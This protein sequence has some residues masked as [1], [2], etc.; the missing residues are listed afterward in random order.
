MTADPYAN[1]PCGSG[2][3]LKFCCGPHWPEIERIER[4]FDSQ[5]DLAAL[6]AINKL[7]ATLPHHAH[8]MNMKIDLLFAQG[9]RE[10]AEAL[11]KEFIAAHPDNVN[12][13][14]RRAAELLDAGEIEQAARLW[15]DTFASTGNT[16][17]GVGL[18]VARATA[19]AALMAGHFAAGRTLLNILMA[20]DPKDTT[21]RDLAVQMMSADGQPPICR[22]LPPLRQRPVDPRWND[23]FAAALAPTPLADFPRAEALFAVLSEKAANEP[24][25]WGNLALLRA[26]LA[27][28]Q[29]AS[30]AYARLAACD[31][32][33]DDA[34]EAEALSVVYRQ[35]ASGAIVEILKAAFELSDVDRALE[36]LSAEKRCGRLPSEM[37]RRDDEDG[38]PP[39]A[40]FLLLDRPQI[41]DA[42]QVEAHDIPV[43][44]G[45]ISIFGK[46]T[47]RPAR[48]VLGAFGQPAFDQA[49][50][51]VRQL[52]GEPLPPF[53]EREIVG[54][55]LAEQHAMSWRP[56]LPA[57]TTA[58]RYYELQVA[59]ER[60]AVQK[61]WPDTPNLALDGKSPRSAASDPALRRRLAAALSLLE[62]S[63]QSLLAPADFAPVRAELKLEAPAPIDPTATAADGTPIPIPVMRLSRIDASKL[64]DEDLFHELD[65][66]GAYAASASVAHLGAEAL[67]RP[68][69]TGETRM[70][71]LLLIARNASDSRSS[72]K[73]IQEIQRLAVQA[74]TSPAP[75]LIMELRVR[76]S[77][78]EPEEIQR[79]LQTLMTK[80]AREP[81]VAQAVGTILQELGLVGPDGRPTMPPPGAA[82]AAAE[83]PGQLWTPESAAASPAKGGLWMPGMD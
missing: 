57:T 7:E 37:L 22:E 49:I 55:I 64:S 2:K 66:A 46:E 59:H 1:C 16:M 40:A 43:V 44:G 48:L 51:S 41:T 63:S 42:S 11:Q 21:I 61:N 24:A 36:L 70:R 5:Q 4:L 13:R 20:L 27:N 54:S 8:L 77:R 9:R 79:L 74:K 50:A 83:D 32:P 62:L 31:I 69:V 73:Y 58:D 75:F 12:A 6:D 81:G 45:E 82:S 72:V 78:R 25:V 15:Y 38:P 26:M 65:R 60:L 67:R 17:T 19:T 53:G 3:K 71:V 56:H 47:D 29:G 23:E 18:V 52:L 14:Y 28:P 35:D 39:R 76:L 10:E 33:W 30:E 34:V 80:H 68:S